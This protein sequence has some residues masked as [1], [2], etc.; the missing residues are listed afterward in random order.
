GGRNIRRDVRAI[1][2]VRD[3]DGVD[4][5][6]A[7]TRDAR[8]CGV[9]LRARRVDDVIVIGVRSCP[10]RRSR[11]LQAFATTGVDGV[12]GA[13]YRLE[14]QGHASGSKNRGQVL[15]RARRYSLAA[16]RNSAMTANSARGKT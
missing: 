12:I 15:P 3:V 13:R 8:R 14:K 1:A 5:A 10:V 2:E 11:S 16:L 9:L 4:Q 6:R 7:R